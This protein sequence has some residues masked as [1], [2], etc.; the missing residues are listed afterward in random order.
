[1]AEET[2]GQTAVEQEFYMPT[3]EDL[4][5][6]H[7]EDKLTEER[8]KFGT[9]LTGNYDLKVDEIELRPSESDKEYAAKPDTT[10]ESKARAARPRAHLSVSLSQEGVSKGKLFFDISWQLQRG[11]TNRMDNKSGVY[12]DFKKHVVPEGKKFSVGEILKAIKQ[13]TWKSKVSELWVKESLPQGDKDRL[14][15]ATTQEQRDIYAKEG[16]EPFNSVNRVWLP[17]KTG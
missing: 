2:A 17:K 3:L 14:K 16:R 1:M 7:T 8:A 4:F 12:E 6:I 9:I 13:F 10:P 5:K 11:P 15:T